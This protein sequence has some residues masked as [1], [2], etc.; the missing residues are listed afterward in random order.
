MESGSRAASHS[1]KRAAL[2]IAL[3]TRPGHQFL[4]SELK[5]A[6]CGVSKVMARRLL[7]G[8]DGVTISP[9][10]DAK[11]VRYSWVGKLPPPIIA[12]TDTPKG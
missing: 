1:R 9:N 6:S 5:T 3:Q 7:K 11:D 4:A 8:V 2:L 12:E 10:E